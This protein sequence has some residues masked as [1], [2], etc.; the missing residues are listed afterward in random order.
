[1]ELTYSHCVGLDVHKKTVVACMTSE[2]IGTFSTMTQDLLA[3]C[4]WLSSQGITQQLDCTGFWK[5]VYNLLEANF[6][7]LVFNAQHIKMFLGVRL[8]LKTLNG[9][10]NCYTMV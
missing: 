3:L 7:V 10:H 6:T 2:Q 5:P 1:M 9:L 8:T 4:D